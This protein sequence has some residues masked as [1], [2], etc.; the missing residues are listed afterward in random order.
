MS[1]RQFI[2]DVIDQTRGIALDPAR[3]DALASHL[4]ACA[5]CA[6]LAERQ[7]AVSS[8]LRRL[9]EEQKDPVSNERELQKLLASFDA[10]RPRPRRLTVGVRLSLAASVLIIV[11]LSVGVKRELPGGSSGGV[12]ATLAPPMGADSTFDVALISP[13]RSRAAAFVILPGATA[14]PRLESGR[15]IRIEIPEAELSSV[16]LWPPMHAG[17]VQADVLVGQDGLARAVRLVQ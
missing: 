12:A 4:R 15:V 8:V 14:L 11:G 2:P 9:A 6:A 10:R 16:G 17:A 5:T 3:L 13:E 7:S 1:C